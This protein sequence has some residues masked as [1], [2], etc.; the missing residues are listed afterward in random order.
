[1]EQLVRMAL[2]VLVVKMVKKENKVFRV[3]LE[4]EV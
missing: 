1:M 2:Q 3:K 4:L